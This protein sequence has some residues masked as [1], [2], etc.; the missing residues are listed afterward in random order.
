M[1]SSNNQSRFKK[2]DVQSFIQEQEN[3]NTL[4]KTASHLKLFREFMSERHPGDNRSMHTIAPSE[5]DSLLSD[6]IV[7]VRKCNDEEYEPSSVRGM[8]SSY[9]RHL[10]KKVMAQA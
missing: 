1:M 4:K 9:D 3:E 8:I 2:L 10:R 7:S 6:F 5:L